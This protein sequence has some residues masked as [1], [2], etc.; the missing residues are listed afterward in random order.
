MS[1]SS[2]T[3]PHITRRSATKLLGGA[4]LS[5][6][7]HSP[8]LAMRS[9]PQRRTAASTTTAQ[10]RRPR[11]PRRHG[12]QR[13]SLLHR[14]GR[15]IHRPGA[16]P[17]QST[18]PPPANSTRTSSPASPPPA[19]ASP[20]S[21][22]P[23]GEATIPTD[24]IKKQVL[25]TLDFHLNKMPNEHGFFYHFND[26]KTGKPLINSEVSSID[27]SILLCGVLTAR[28][29]FN[30]PKITAPRHAALQPRRLAMDAQ[31]RQNL[32]HGLATRDRL[33]LH[34]L[35]PLQRADDAL[36]SRH[37]L[38]DPSRLRPSPGTPSRARR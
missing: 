29:Y 37:R 38:A 8:P 1:V 11:F 27:T 23:T 30:D 10:R 5:T 22:S 12:A 21:A 16:R 31:R 4:L 24:R 13:L 7:V 18:R 25:T 17:R 26:V 19:S 32:L 15:P 2:S 33:H 3:P 14:A 34:P 20:R 9:R 36:S 6:L 35:G 28:A